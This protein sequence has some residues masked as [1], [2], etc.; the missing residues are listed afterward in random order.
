MDRSDAVRRV[1]VVILGVNLALV[2]AKGGV[3]LLTGSLAV[4]SEAVNSLADT[5]YSLVIVAGLYLTT[6][7]PDFEHPHGHERIE[8]FVSLVVALGVFTAGVAVFWQAASAVLTGTYG[9]FAG[10]LGLVVLGA[11]A[12]VKL[13]LYRYCLRMSEQYRSPA[14]EA[15]ALDNRND[16]LTAVAALVG[17]LG[18][19]LGFPLLD[20]LAAAVVSLGIV[21]TG[22]EIVRDNLSYLVGAAPPEDLRIEILRRAFAH[23]D[24]KGAH[25]VVAHYVGP[26]IDVSLHIE[27]EGEMT[28]LEAHDIETEVMDAIRALPQVD[29]VFV[30]VDPKELGEWKHD[31][32][33]EFFERELDDPEREFDDSE[34][35]VGDFEREFGDSERAVGDDG[36]REDDGSSTVPDGGRRR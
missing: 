26:E 24:V 33:T 34:R 7:P 20:P 14:L 23:P 25:D 18:A 35:A 17:V 1:G 30:H 4:G 36:G 8:P 21:Y 10:R 9:G 13:G 28:L 6:Q 2:A 22:V 3:W 15:T 27:V 16:V 5:V 31:D 11:G 32:T 29:D 19:S 12:V